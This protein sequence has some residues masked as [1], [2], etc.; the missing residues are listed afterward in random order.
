VPA[1]RTVEAVR[2][3]SV[4][5]STPSQ[6][7]CGQ[8]EGVRRLVLTAGLSGVRIVAAVLSVALTIAV[9]LALRA[10]H[11]P[12]GATTLIVSL[13]ILRTGP[14]LLTIVLAVVWLLDL[15][16]R[17]RRPPAGGG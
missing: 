10:P 2:P 5:V 7:A 12:A 6:T 1:S 8:G 16:A 17:T 14:Q 13:G 15:V 3:R 4:P 11:A 9:L